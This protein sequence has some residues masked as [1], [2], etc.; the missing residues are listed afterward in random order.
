[1]LIALRGLVA[2]SLAWAVVALA[3]QVIVAR[4]GGRHDHSR[5]AG[6][7]ARG[8]L[9][10]FTTAMRPDHKESARLHPIAFGIGVLMHVGVVAA[11]FG[12][13]TLVLHPPTGD[14][15]LGAARPVFA[16]AL[17]AG[18]TLTI[19]RHR[20][21]TLR[22]MSTPDDHLAVAATCV[23]LAAA[24]FAPFGA[25][26]TIAFLACAVLFLVYL[27]LGKLRHAVFFFIARGDYARR[28]GYRGVYPPDRPSDAG[29]TVA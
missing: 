27:P 19:R 17:L 1:M 8:V 16:A 14:A 21:A 25:P 9:Y 22:A 2:V 15:V 11:L 23:L 5:R 28:L 10:G 12:V 13:V 3:F 26:A 18:V 6:S 20:S 4:G 29:V 7:R 24:F